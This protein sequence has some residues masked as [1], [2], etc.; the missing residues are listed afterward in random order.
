MENRMNKVR[1]K[2]HSYE[3]AKD[4]ER[5][6]RFLLDTY[7]PGIYHDNWLQPRWEYMHYHPWLDK[8]SLNKIG[9]WESRGGIVSVATYEMA[10]GLTY[11]QYHPDYYYLKNEMLE[12][13]ETNLFETTPEGQRRIAVF[14]NDFDQELTDIVKEHGYKLVTDYRDTWSEIEMRKHFPVELP[15]GFH[16]QSLEDENDIIKL[17]RLIH[18]GFDHPG[19][20]LEGAADGTKHMQD[21]PDYRKGLNIVAVTDNGAYVAYSGVWLDRNKVV[22]IEPVCTDPD[23]RR[24][25][26][27]TATLF[28]CFNRCLKEGAKTITIG[29]EQL[30][31]KSMGYKH[32]FFTNLWTKTLLKI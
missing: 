1:V 7:Q 8:T 24:L 13:A 32:L 3:H 10:P 15:P 20:P 28:E 16:L 30:F 9:I 27:G 23:Y 19:E 6:N 29:S 12:Y 22:Y 21:A 26:L 4:Y 25:G 17:T 2:L 31:Y 11:F 5:V 18:R 14:V